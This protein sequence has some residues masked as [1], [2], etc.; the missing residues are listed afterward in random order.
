MNNLHRDREVIERA[1][2]RVSPQGLIL[3]GIK[4]SV[5]GRHVKMYFQ[6]NG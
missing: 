4:I 1:R 5:Q 3:A 6:D 2:E